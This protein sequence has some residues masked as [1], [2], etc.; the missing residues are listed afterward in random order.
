MSKAKN[1]FSPSL[2]QLFIFQQYGEVIYRVDFLFP[3]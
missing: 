2:S 1:K 3:Q